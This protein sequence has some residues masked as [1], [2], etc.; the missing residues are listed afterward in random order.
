MEAIPLS[1]IGAAD[2]AHASAKQILV[3]QKAREYSK[4]ESRHGKMET[5]YKVNWYAF[6][7]GYLRTLK[8]Q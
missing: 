4:L 7:V 3:G 2:C 8:A 6:R 1:A 5:C